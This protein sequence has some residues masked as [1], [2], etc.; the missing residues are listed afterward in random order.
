MAERAGVSSAGCPV[1]DRASS[2][3]S[4]PSNWAGMAITECPPMT[5]RLA[6]IRRRLPAQ[7]SFTPSD[8]RS[9][10]WLELGM[11]VTAIAAA[12]LLSFAH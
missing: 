4:G 5:D 12:V 9:M 2:A 10:R 6:D 1:G 8:E 7:Q 3:P 11:A